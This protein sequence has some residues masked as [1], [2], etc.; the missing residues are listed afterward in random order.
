MPFSGFNKI[1]LFDLKSKVR[2]T[3]DVYFSL[4]EKKKDE[5]V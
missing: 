3:P 2:K 5:T 4:P 1:L